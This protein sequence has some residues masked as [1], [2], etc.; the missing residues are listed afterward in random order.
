MKIYV[1]VVKDDPDAF[2]RMIGGIMSDVDEA[3]EYCAETTLVSYA[4]THGYNDGDR[5]PVIVYEV[6]PL[7]PKDENP[8][9]DIEGDIHSLGKIVEER[10]VEY[11]ADDEDLNDLIAPYIFGED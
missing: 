10:Q 4:E 11:Q 8:I 9:Y 3:I 6:L 1:A 5:L 7:N 2:D